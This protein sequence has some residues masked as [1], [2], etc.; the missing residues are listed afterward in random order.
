MPSDIIMVMPMQIDP[1][2]MFYFLFINSD[3]DLKSQHLEL[4]IIPP[5]HLG[6]KYNIYALMSVLCD[7]FITELINY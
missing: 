3:Y 2:E 1:K 6:T 4:G 5:K 7:Y